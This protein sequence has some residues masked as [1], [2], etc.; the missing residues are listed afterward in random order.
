MRQFQQPIFL[1][2]LLSVF[3]AKARAQQTDPTAGHHISGTFSHISIDS[4]VTLIETQVPVHFYYNSSQFD[5]L[6]ID[7]TVKARE[8]GKR[9]GRG[10]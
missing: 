5:S 7:L 4:L 6:S 3:S 1:L 8:K 9:G 2:L 10:R